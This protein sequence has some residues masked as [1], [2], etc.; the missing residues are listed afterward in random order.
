MLLTSIVNLSSDKLF[1]V[2]KNCAENHRSA[3]V[4]KMF[5]NSCE[6]R[7]KPVTPMPFVQWNIHGPNKSR[8][9]NFK[10]AARKILEAAIVQ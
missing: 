3:Q 5:Y 7:L 2:K 6:F 1:L 10:T 9:S 4:D 8:A